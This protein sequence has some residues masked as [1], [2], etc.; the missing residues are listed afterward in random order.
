MS[1]LKGPGPGRP[2]G[3]TNVRTRQAQELMAKHN[4]DPILANL[5]LI[6]IT[7]ERLLDDTTLS[8]MEQTAVTKV[9]ADINKEMLKYSYP[10]LKAV[11]IV[12]GKPPAKE[13]STA[14]LKARAKAMLEDKTE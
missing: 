10:Q 1:N 3:G 6:Q 12:D 14:E 7:K 11:E 5:E 4:Y 9:L 8:P 13:L 2:A